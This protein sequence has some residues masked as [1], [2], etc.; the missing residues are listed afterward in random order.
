MK[1][2]DF[3][4]QTVDGA[5]LNGEWVPGFFLGK[6]S[7]GWYGLAEYGSRYARLAQALAAAGYTTYAHDHRGHGKSV[8]EGSAPG[9]IAS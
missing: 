6:R 1:S 3:A 5:N 4:F 8:P 9:H 2:V 7:L